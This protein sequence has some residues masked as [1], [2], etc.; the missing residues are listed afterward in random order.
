[1]R[2]EPCG[3]VFS[4]L[5]RP[6]RPVGEEVFALREGDVAVDVANVYQTLDELA[7][8]AGGAERFHIIDVG[9]AIQPAE[10][11][12]QLLG[13]ALRTDQTVGEIRRAEKLAR[14]QID[15]A[16]MRLRGGPTGAQREDLTQLAAGAGVHLRLHA[17]R[18][19][20]DVGRR[21]RGGDGGGAFG[22]SAHGDS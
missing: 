7:L 12:H 17:R 14:N 15:G 5:V 21:R 1:M 18:R 4:H 19:N 20:G 9:E 3:D 22:A 10:V 8:A 16:A 2:A 13:R 11:D 6:L